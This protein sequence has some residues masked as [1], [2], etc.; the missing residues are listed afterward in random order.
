MKRGER[1]LH[2]TWLTEDY[3]PLVVEITRVTRDA[4]YYRG[5]YDGQV[6]GDRMWTTYDRAAKW[7]KVA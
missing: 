2:P 3:K 5:V 6:G 7:V 1:Y 4:V